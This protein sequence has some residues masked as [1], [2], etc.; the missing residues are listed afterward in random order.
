MRDNR[1]LSRYELE[2][3]GHV[4]FA[5]YRQEGTQLV[6]EHVEAPTALRGTGAAGRLMQGIMDEANTRGLT[7]VP[8]C[9]YAASWISRHT[10]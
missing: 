7:V 3:Q 10:R 9:S 2:E 5:R 4:A 1:T 6:I 8:L